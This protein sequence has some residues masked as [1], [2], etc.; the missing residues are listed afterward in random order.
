[1]KLGNP[2]IFPVDYYKGNITYISRERMKYIGY[3]KYMQN[4]IYAS[5]APDNYLYLKSSNPQYLYLKKVRITGI[6]EDAEAASKL[7]CSDDC[8][9]ET[10]DILDKDFPIEDALVSPLV[11]LIVEELTKSEYKPSDDENNAK[12]DLSD[13]A[14]FLRNNTKSSLAKALD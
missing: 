4:I 11:Q 8:S 6:F 10:C 14:T 13:L 5:I 7:Q 2:V 1:M 12:D 9:T 3:N